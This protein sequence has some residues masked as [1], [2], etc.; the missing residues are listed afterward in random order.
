MTFTHQYQIEYISDFQ[1]LKW[2]SCKHTTPTS[3]T[4]GVT[5]IYLMLSNV[6]SLHEVYEVIHCGLLN[7]G[8]LHFNNRF[9]LIKQTH[10]VSSGVGGCWTWTSWTDVVTNGLWSIG[11]LDAQPNYLK[12]LWRQL[13]IAKL[14]IQ[15]KAATL[16]DI[17][18]VST[19][20]AC[21]VKTWKICGIVLH[22][23]AADLRLSF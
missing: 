6:Y 15:S 3:L 10:C 21:T 22:D 5:I 13:T 20:I 7:F 19:S 16:L 23:K 14:P 1:I 12:L 8:K 11:L 18:E 9:S 17:P 4:F 2:P